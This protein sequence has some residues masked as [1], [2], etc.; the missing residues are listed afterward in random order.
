MKNCQTNKRK[1]IFWNNA[2]LITHFFQADCPS[3]PF[4]LSETDDIWHEFLP[5]HEF[6]QHSFNCVQMVEESEERLSEE[7]IEELI[8]TV[9]DILPGDPE[10]ENAAPADAE[11]DEQSW[12]SDRPEITP[13]VGGESGW[14]NLQFKLKE[15]VTD[16]VCSVHLTVFKDFIITFILPEMEKA[17]SILSDLQIHKHVEWNKF[18]WH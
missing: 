6:F 4:K 9:A 13:T 16:R 14:L 15:K 7:Q 11:M 2:G 3:V 1:S 12:C 5:V 17:S 8:Q 18:I 10:Q